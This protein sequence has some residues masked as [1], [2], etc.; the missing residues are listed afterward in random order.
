[1]FVMF[2]VDMQIF[3]QENFVY[4]GGALYYRGVYLGVVPGRKVRRYDYVRYGNF[5]IIGCSDIA[6]LV[7]LRLGSMKLV[8]TTGVKELMNC[9]V[10]NLVVRLGN[11]IRFRE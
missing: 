8:G 7:I 3:L 5:L 4:K 1:M 6:G 11:I 10:A 9:E 2:L